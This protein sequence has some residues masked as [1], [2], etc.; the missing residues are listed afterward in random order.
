[1]QNT[2]KKK[3]KQGRYKALLTTGRYELMEAFDLD[4]RIEKC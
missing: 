3:L 4:I 1:M 2:K